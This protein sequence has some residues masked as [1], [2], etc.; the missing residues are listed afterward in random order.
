[1]QWGNTSHQGASN[2]LDRWQSLTRAIPKPRTWTQLR[3]LRCPRYRSMGIGRA[4]TRI[5]KYRWAI[6]RNGQT[7]LL[8]DR[9]YVLYSRVD[10][11]W[12]RGYVQ[13]YMQL[14]SC[15]HFAYNSYSYPSSICLNFELKLLKWDLYRSNRNVNTIRMVSKSCRNNVFSMIITTF[16]KFHSFCKCFGHGFYTF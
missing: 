12:L 6:V 7:S 10:C 15:R 13:V 9:L 3:F 16:C 8:Q 2:D 4:I 11:S 14:H 5:H 1:M